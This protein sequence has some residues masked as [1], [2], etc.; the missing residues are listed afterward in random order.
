STTTSIA[1]YL[2]QLLRDKHNVSTC[3]PN[4]FLHCE[5]LLNE[6]IERVRMEMIGLKAESP[7]SSFLASLPEPE[8]DKV[9]IIEKVF[10]PVNRFPNY[11]FVGRLLGPRGMTM[12]QLEL[13]IGCKVKIRGKGSLRD[14]KREEQ[15]RGKQN[16]EHLQ[17]ELHVVIEVEDTPTRAQIKLEKAKDEINKLLIPVSEEDDELKRKQLEDLRLLNG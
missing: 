10:I 6:E 13:N 14:R 8:G 3:A 1:E 2:K 5:R 16:W 17:E 7:N 11:N 15:L 9:Q 4:T 12:R